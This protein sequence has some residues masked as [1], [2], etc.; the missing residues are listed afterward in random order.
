[1]ARSVLGPR[2]TGYGW[3]RINVGDGREQFFFLGIQTRRLAPNARSV[4]YVLAED[5]GACEFLV[6]R[7][8]LGPR[9]AV[10]GWARTWVMGENM[11]ANYFFF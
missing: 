9:F 5:A 11:G 3:A 10:Y 6:A 7:S 2:F 8:V 1:M 4:E